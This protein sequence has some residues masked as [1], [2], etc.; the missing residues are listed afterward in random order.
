MDLE[1]A[2][3]DAETFI[4]GVYKTSN[5]L[6]PM[7]VFHF[8]D[9]PRHVCGLDMSDKN[10]IARMLRQHVQQHDPD[11]YVMMTEAWSVQ[12]SDSEPPQPGDL[13]RHPD[14]VEVVTL[15]AE[16]RVNAALITHRIH[17]DESGKVLRLEKMT[18]LRFDGSSD[19]YAEGRFC[20][21]LYKHVKKS[22]RTLN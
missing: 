19:A 12:T 6:L 13:S 7:A 20:G 9:G 17:R 4:E 10:F 2:I 8:D 3:K 1:T 5:E 22:G 14:R 15:V 21:V 18:D 11:A 16:T